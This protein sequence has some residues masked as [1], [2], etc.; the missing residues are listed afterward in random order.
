[1]AYDNFTKRAFIAS[2]KAGAVKVVDVTNPTS[3]QEVSGGSLDV[4]ATMGASC[5]MPS[6]TY[7]GMDFGGAANPCGYAPTVAIIVNSF[8]GYSFPSWY[9]GP[10]F[11]QTSHP[12]KGA[13]GELLDSPAKCQ[14][15]C[16]KTSNCAFW[17]Y[18]LERQQAGGPQYNECFLK[19]DYT[20]AMAADKGKSLAEC[21][22]YTIWES[23]PAWDLHGQ[24]PN[25]KGAAGPKSCG[26]FELDSVQ[27][28]AV[29]RVPN[30]PYSVVV[31]AAPAKFEFADGYLGFFNAQTLAYLG[32]APAGIKPEGIASD[33]KGKVACVNEGST[34]VDGSRNLDRHGS[35]TMCDITGDTPFLNIHC[36]TYIPSVDTFAPGMFK[37]AVE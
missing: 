6:C 18:E 37:T 19:G 2:S 33:G 12:E 5:Q 4:K 15:L 29:T 3:L 30:Y 34:V 10:K 31:A 21:H 13:I 1:M 14:I 8:N 36:S 11:N 35:M 20:S 27:S 17:S 9:S 28:V 23:G 25:W 24:D 7:E 26:T 16:Q 22:H 32:C